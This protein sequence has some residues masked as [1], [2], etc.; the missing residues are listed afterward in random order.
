MSDI[1]T[2]IA[3]S[4]PQDQATAPL[5][6]EAQNDQVTEQTQ[7]QPPQETT[8]EPQKFTEAE[9]LKKERKAVSNR[10]RKIGK[11]VA[12][13]EQLEAMQS[14]PQAAKQQKPNDDGAPKESD[15]ESYAEFLEARNDWKIEQKLKER[16]G[17]QEQ[18]FKAEQEKQWVVNRTAE[19]DKESVEFAKQYPQFNAVIE[20]HAETIQELPDSIKVQLLRT[21]NPS[22]ALLNLAESGV[23]EELGSMSPEDA[24][25]EI[26]LAL[27][28][29]PT[30]PPQ[31]SNAPKPLAAARGVVSG[32]KDPNTM[33]GR[34]LRQRYGLT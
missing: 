34:E 1:D 5:A 7:E 16:E 12:R 11:L 3:E 27:R 21:N 6:Q 28:Q 4:F 13:I 25:V 22:L 30:K 15:Y 23:L 18:T 20:E 8:Q 33:S 9:W 2:T 19:V 31:K 29:Q 14:Q 32:V 26:R 10:D 17:K 24:R